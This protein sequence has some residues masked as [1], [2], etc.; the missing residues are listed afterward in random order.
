MEKQ[1]NQVKFVDF[2][3]SHWII[4]ELAD[5]GTGRADNKFSIK[6]RITQKVYKNKT[7]ALEDQ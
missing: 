5:D 1:K 4:Q 6:N 7:A 2:P 3:S